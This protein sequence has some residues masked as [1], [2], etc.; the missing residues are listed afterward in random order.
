MLGGLHLQIK[1]SAITKRI[2]NVYEQISSRYKYSTDTQICRGKKIEKIPS[3]AKVKDENQSNSKCQSAI[4]SKCK[5]TV[6][7]VSIQQNRVSKVKQLTV[8]FRVTI[9]LFCITSRCVCIVIFF[10]CRRSV[11]F[12]LFVFSASNWMMRLYSF[13]VCWNCLLLCKRSRVEIKV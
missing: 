10:V 2:E 6:S 9:I 5:S 13:I 1:F 11:F 7:T 4:R 12:L 8:E 3:R